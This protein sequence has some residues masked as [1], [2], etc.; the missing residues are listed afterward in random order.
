VK[1]Q[2]TLTLRVAAHQT[3]HVGR[4]DLRRPREVQ[5]LLEAIGVVAAEFFPLGEGVR[6]APLA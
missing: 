6:R 4:V 5:R 1:V 3:D 2:L